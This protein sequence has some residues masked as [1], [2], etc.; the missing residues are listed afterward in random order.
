MKTADSEPL[1]SAIVPVHNAARYL[2]ET[3]DSLRNQTLREIEI[4]CVENG[5]TDESATILQEYAARDGRFRIVTL[6]P[7]GAGAARNEGIDVAR[8]KYVSMHDADDLFEPDMLHIL[9]QNAERNNSDIVMGGVDFLYENERSEP[10][11]WLF[12]AE[13]LKSVNRN[14]FCPSRELPDHV[15]DF[16]FTWTWGKI[17]RKDFLNRH[18][19]R[20]LTIRRA[21]DV[22]FM[23][24]AL[25]FARI[26]S[27]EEQ[28]FTHYRQ[29]ADSLSHN[30]ETEPFVFLEA[31][32]HMR[33]V[34]REEGTPPQVM[35]CLYKVFLSELN[36]QGSIMSPANQERFYASILPETEA[37]FQ[38]LEKLG[39]D[40]DM[41]GNLSYAA[42]KRFIAPEASVT[43]EI[44]GS[45]EKLLVCLSSLE[46][47]PVEIWLDAKNPAAE[48]LARKVSQKIHHLN[49]CTPAN[50]S[51]RIPRGVIS[52]THFIPTGYPLCKLFS[53]VGD[54]GG[55]LQLNRFAKRQ[56]NIPL[57]YLCNPGRQT[58]KI[59]G[60][61]VITRAYSKKGIRWFLL[62]RNID[63]FMIWRKK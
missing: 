30:M 53:T 10:M 16:T 43:V 15:F 24:K 44:N 21:E 13:A 42:Y 17:F 29:H 38:L 19:I 52:S 27:I 5:S 41:E 22:P 55:A 4:I 7:V 14:C 46:P 62:G 18:A 58:W 1:V 2:R 3:L 11:P 26:V 35:Q 37:E 45:E 63:R 57:F 33:R 60:A 54:G 12:S 59:F 6:P 39:N 49:G 31:F 9:F 32:R 50:S 61:P 56:A 36:Y 40:P 8:G 20:Y 23:F 51:F 25:F 28:V 47:Y 34:L 48:E